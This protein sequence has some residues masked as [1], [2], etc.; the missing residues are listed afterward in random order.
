MLVSYH[1]PYD[2]KLLLLAIPAVSILWSEGRPYR[3]TALVVTILAMTFTSDLP[4]AILS[5]LTRGVNVSAM[6]MP[7]RIILLC[8]LRP[9]PLALLAMAAIFL[10]FYI[11]G[12]FVRGPERIAAERASR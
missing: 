1:R 8:A 2:A 10:W 6:G 5:I 11:R 3:S 12:A 7:S 4:L 9:A